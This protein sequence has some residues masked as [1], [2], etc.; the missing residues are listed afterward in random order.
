MVLPA[1]SPL[2]AAPTV[3]RRRRRGLVAVLIAVPLVVLAVGVAAWFAVNSSRPAPPAPGTTSFTQPLLIPELAPSTLEDGVRVFRLEPR[4]SRTTFVAQGETPTLGYNGSYLGPTLVAA[5]GE[6]VRVEVHNAL[7]ESTTVHWHGMHLPAVMDGGPHTPIAAG[8]TWAPEWLIDQPAAS[9]WYHPH[10]HGR[11][12]EQVDA[13]LAG[14]FLLTDDTEGALAL[15]REYGVDD[16]PLIVQDRSFSADGAFAGGLGMQFDGV[17]GDTILVNGTVGPY[18]EAS[19]ERVRLRLLNGSSARMYDFAFDDGRTF[20]LIGT[21]GGLLT[22]PVPVTSIPLSPGERAE[23]VVTV[24]PGDETVL[25]SQAP[26]P[27]LHAGGAAFDVLQ[28]RSAASLTPSPEVP[29]RLVDIQDASDADAAAHRTFVMSGHDIND[30]QMDLGRVDFAAIVD[31]REVWTVRNDNPLPHSFH[32]HDTQF[33]V[34]SIDGEPPPARLSGW[35]DT[36]PLEWDREY[37]LLV[38]FEDYVDPTTPYMFHCHL[39]WHEDQGMMGQFLV[40]EEGQQPDL[41]RPEGDSDDHHD[42]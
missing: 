27:A 42:H 35:K 31:T 6:R 1:P 29:R 22:A 17:L 24:R 28:L 21:D 11:T 33:R 39:L 8:T 16:V 7:D 9:L 32:V 37:R 34:L 4:E 14:M 3:P 23:I 2:P 40:V 26:D 38:S 19:T 30:T 20:D 18:F 15:P 12:R 5:R 25:R 41:R 36:I 13:G 10:L